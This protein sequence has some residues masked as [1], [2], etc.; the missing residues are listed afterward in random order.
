MRNILS[1]LFLL[2]FIACSESEIKEESQVEVKTEETSEIENEDPNPDQ[3]N[4]EG[5]SEGERNNIEI[6]LPQTWKLVKMTCPSSEDCVVTGEEMTYQDLYSFKQDMSVQKLRFR[7]NDTLEI[8]GDFT[9]T[10]TQFGTY[11]FN[12]K[13]QG[14]ATPEDIDIISSCT[15]REEYLFITENDQEVLKNNY[16]ACDGPDLYYTQLKE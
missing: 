5:S 9:V 15:S 4:N 6:D 1:L 8:T 3:S 12:I 16:S 14:E 13:Y 2:M 7:A 11:A 10:E